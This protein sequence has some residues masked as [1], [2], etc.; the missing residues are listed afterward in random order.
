M[1]ILTGNDLET[2]DV[3][4]WTGSGWSRHVAEAVAV[5]AGEG[6]DQTAGIIAREEGKRSVNQPYEVEAGDDGLPLHMK[7]RMRAR[8]PT[9]RPDLGVQAE[10]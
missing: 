3:V 10:G 5:E 2:G 8:G 7:E 1:L 9:V 6:P 4:W